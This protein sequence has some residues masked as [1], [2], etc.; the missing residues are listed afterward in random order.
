MKLSELR[1][2][3]ILKVTQKKKETFGHSF[4]VVMEPCNKDICWNNTIYMIPISS[5]WTILFP[6][7][8]EQVSVEELVNT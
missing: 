3:L 8:K 5:H 1:E 6:I 4:Q 7:R 2:K